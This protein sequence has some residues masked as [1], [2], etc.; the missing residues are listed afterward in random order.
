MLRVG[1]IAYYIPEIVPQIA[2]H[3]PNPRPP[4]FPLCNLSRLNLREEQTR[5]Q[6][7]SSSLPTVTTVDPK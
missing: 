2:D 6:A 3:L 5:P 1:D 4:H 7:R